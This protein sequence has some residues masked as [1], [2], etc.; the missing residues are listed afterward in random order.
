MPLESLLDPRSI[1]ILG[2]SD[3][4]SIGRALIESLDRMRFSGEVF[5]VN[6]RYTEL[7]GRRCYASL[8][9]LPAAPDAVVLCVSHA[10]VLDGLEDAAAKGARGAV[11]YDGGFAERGPEGR[12]LQERVVA[13]C[14]DAGMALAG[15]NCMGILNPVN[16][17]TL[18]LHEVRETG[19]LSGNVGLISQSG[20][21]CIGMLADLRRFGY[22]HVI[23]SGNE[24]VLGLADYLDALIAEPATQVI[25]L[26]VESVREPDRFVAGLDRAAAAGKPV[27]VLKVGRSPRTRNA[28]TSHTGGLAGESQVFSEVLRAHRAIEVD[29]LDELAEV[30][31][32]CQGK[33]PPSGARLGV[34]TASGGQAELIL[35]LAETCGL[36]LPPLPDDI[37]A[38]AE[39][40]IGP[41]TGDGNPL[42]A[43]GS[44]NFRDNFPHALAVLDADPLCDAVVLCSDA[45]DHNPMG[46]VDRS[47]EYGQLLVD[48]AARSR[49]PH[50][51][52]GMRPGL[53][54]GAQLA[55]M[56]RHGIA[57][58]GGTRQGLGAIARLAR[59]AAPPAAVM[60]PRSGGGETLAALLAD[61]SRTTIN[62]AD[63]KKVLAAAGLP[64]SRES[65]AGTVEE[66]V[67]AG[68]AIG[69]P[70]VLKVVSDDIAHKT[71]YR[72]VI[73]GI[74]DPDGLRAGWRTLEMRVADHAP[75]PNIAGYLV[76][77]MV[78]DGIEVFA[79]VTRDPDYGLMLAFGLGGTAIEVMRDFSLRA[80]P[81]RAGDAR[82]MIRGI[83]GAALLDGARATKPYDVDSLVT[84]IEAL[85]A[86]AHAGRQWLGEI[87]INPIIVL[88]AG[89]GCRIVD[90]LIIPR[91]TQ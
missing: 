85:A 41:M 64:V 14:R 35:D 61:G 74:N 25:A 17:S 20:S 39:R 49:K 19:A 22:S 51:L 13:I 69:Y 26:F 62:E 10:R 48:A 36:D 78:R 9:E 15:P 52:M 44:G 73:A 38:E 45:S 82:A 46:R 65:L 29:D 4:P 12:A 37:R 33:V 77:E 58:I 68:A 24:A 50:F 11:I 55:L 8:A 63:A 81:L 79:G 27:V 47:L 60:S 59:W 57:V 1:A 34:V 30:I 89:R 3:R 83:R 84:C 54:S 90:A 31:A 42:D 21:I 88:P 87:D 76:Q 18:Y 28:I 6:P 72:L 70:L 91:K 7:L 71:E 5:A 16:N 40:V 53:M 66:A 75:Q 43:W 67:E 2:A 80:L 86:F 56:Q 23:S 32:V